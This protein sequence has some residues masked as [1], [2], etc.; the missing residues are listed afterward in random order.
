GDGVNDAPA[1]KKADVGIAMG[2][3]TDVAKEASALILTEENFAT[4]VGAVREG[5]VIYDNIRKFVRYMLTT[6]LGE[7]AT[8]LFAMV[9]GLPIPLLPVQILWINLVTDGLPAV[10][11]GFEAAEG[12]VMARPPRRHAEGILARGLWQH[13]VWVAGL[14]GVLTIG[15]MYFTWVR[16]ADLK[17]A[18]TVTFTVLVFTQMGHVMGIR[19]ESRSLWKIGLFSNY[20]LLAAVFLTVVAQLLI[21]YL[22]PLQKI[23]HT[24]PLSLGNLALCLLPAFV[25]YGAVELEKLWRRRRKGRNH[26]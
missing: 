15:L 19:S 8:M 4:I 22:S 2:R 17:L 18:Q 26:V 23:F 1:L 12:D 3:G 10:A 16:H 14:M 9:L 25:I 21:L 13:T 5:R 11:L 6:N 20:R 7:I 24:S